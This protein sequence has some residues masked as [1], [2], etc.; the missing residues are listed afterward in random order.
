[1]LIFGLN[2]PNVTLDFVR[3]RSRTGSSAH[4]STTSRGQGSRNK[5]NLHPHLYIETYR[6]WVSGHNFSR[7]YYYPTSLIGSSEC[8]F[9][10][11][12]PC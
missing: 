12:S 10:I 3:Y 6:N 9:L 11:P 8:Q 7:K 5:R 1:M 2:R 4:K